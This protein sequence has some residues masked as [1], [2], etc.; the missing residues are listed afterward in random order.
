M[1]TAIFQPRVQGIALKGAS[2]GRFFDRDPS[3]LRHTFSI[4]FTVFDAAATVQRFALIDADYWNIHLGRMPLHERGWVLQERLLA[5][6][7]WHFCSDQIAWECVET[8]AAETYPDGLPAV[9][10]ETPTAHFK[11]LDASIAGKRL[12]GPDLGEEMEPKVLAHHLWPRIVGSYSQCMLS[13]SE[14]KL[15]ALL[16]IAKR[17]RLILQDEYVV[18]MWRRYLASE[19]GWYVIDH[20]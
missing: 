1:H 17:M 14:D 16:G 15:I 3:L 5:R 20:R 9:L 6:R 18:G 12:K 8:D 2:S 7:V 11:S 10:A 19:R 13:K 4:A